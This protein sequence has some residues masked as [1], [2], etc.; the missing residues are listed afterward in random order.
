MPEVSLSVDQNSVVEG[1][2]VT[3]TI[4]LS[5][6]LA[7]NVTIPLTL[8]QGT[9]EADDYDSASPVNVDITSGQ[10]EAEYTI[11]T[12]DDADTENETFM[13]AIDEG[14]LP[15]GIILGS[16]TSA[17]V[18]ITDNDMREVNLSVDQNSVAEGQ[19]VTV[20]IALSETLANNTTIPLVLTPGTAESDDYDST[21]PVNVIITGGQTEAE[22]TI[23][24]YEDADT[25]NETFMVAIDEDNLPAG[26]ILGSSTSAEVKITDNDMP[27]ILAPVS[28]EIDEGKSEAVQI[29]LMTQPSSDVT[30]TITG[31]E[32]ADLEPDQKD[33][34]F[35]EDNYNTPQT[36]TLIT[37]EDSD[38]LNDEVTLTLAAS[39]GGYD[40]VSQTLAV[41]IRDNMGV[42]IEDEE[43]SIS[44]TLWGN[45]P[46]PVS[47]LT[48]IVFDLPEPAQIS[49]RVTD[50][51]GRIVQTNPYGWYE[52]GRDHTVEIGTDNLT[53]GVYYYTLRVDMGDQVI[54]RSKAMSVVR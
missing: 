3:V 42:G 31:Y 25:E 50:L 49:V 7:I 8:T 29:S 46:N 5:E 43:P 37:T 24:T 52:A 15:T 40:E 45:Y 51:L 23:K 18:T 36:V 4:E 28:V 34:I 2:P 44:I 35:T 12:Y 6:T 10:T 16:S 48:K 53:S 17:E 38:L 27:G 20:T 41:T 21:S 1:Q 30:V 13:V 19:P 26:I 47:D 11:K 14:N 9:A 22:H 33:L 32:N 39:G 54:Q